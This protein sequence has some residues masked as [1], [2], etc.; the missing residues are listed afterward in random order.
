MPLVSADHV[1]IFCRWF[2]ELDPVCHQLFEFY[3]SREESLK[4]FALEFIPSLI[5]LYLRYLSLN[6]KK[7]RA[8]KRHKRQRIC[9]CVRACVRACVFVSSVCGFCKF[10]TQPAKKKKKVEWK[11]IYCNGW[12]PVLPDKGPTFVYLTKKPSKQRKKS[13]VL[14]YCCGFFGCFPPPP[15][16][17]HTHFRV[18]VI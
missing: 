5:G 10:V 7:V 15:P 13:L 14:F 3:R 11:E 9:V 12:M 16:H 4:R 6:D 1:C 2:Q 17:T 8:W 18:C